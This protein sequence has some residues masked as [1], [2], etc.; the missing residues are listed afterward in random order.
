LSIKAIFSPQLG[1]LA[2]H[3]NLVNNFDPHSE[4]SNLRV[5][6]L[7]ITYNGSKFINEQMISIIDNL[8]KDDELIVIDDKSTDDTVRYVEERLGQCHCNTQLHCNSENVG[9]QKNI[10]RGIRLASNDIIVFSDQDDIWLENKIKFIKNAFQSDLALYVHNAKYFGNSLQNINGETSFENLKI[11]K[12]LF[13]NLIRNQYIGCCM[14][15][16]KR[17]FEFGVLDKLEKSV[18]HDWYLAC[19]AMKNKLRIKI[20][21]QIHILHRR[22]AENLTPKKTSFKTKLIMRA[23]MVWILQ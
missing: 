12:N 5:S 7:M 11:S 19:Y 14:A 20:D 15:I 8:T 17:Y 6:V 1:K 9:I 3:S 22:H 13:K 4:P 23:K 2:I 10:S 21:N 18:M 16:D